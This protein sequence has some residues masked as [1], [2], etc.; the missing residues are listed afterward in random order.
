MPLEEKIVFTISNVDFCSLALTV[1]H[2][3]LTL[4]IFCNKLRFLKVSHACNFKCL[5][6]MQSDRSGNSGIE[7]GWLFC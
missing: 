4:T 1:L 2:V 5:A 6:I 7:L 3:K